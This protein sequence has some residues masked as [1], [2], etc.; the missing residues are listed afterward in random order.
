MI[1]GGA[2]TISLQSL[3][4]IQATLLPSAPTVP[5]QPPPFA[6]LL[7]YL[8]H[9]PSRRATDAC[10]RQVHIFNH[11]PICNNFKDMF[12]YS[13]TANLFIFVA[14]AKMSTLGKSTHDV[15]AG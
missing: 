9:L 10:G 12:V 11:G 14:I 6:P 2:Q 3:G 8:Q 5:F 1:A 13:P 4:G 7:S 15:S